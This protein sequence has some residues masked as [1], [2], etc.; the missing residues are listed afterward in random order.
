MKK[1]KH[2]KIFVYM[3]LLSLFGLLMIYSA[4]C[5][6]SNVKYGDSFLFV[7]KQAVGFL[8]GLVLFVFF[9]RFD[10]HKFYKFRWV[11][12]ITSVVLL[13]LVFV[14]HIGVTSNGARRWVGFGAFTIQ[15][16]EVAKFGFVIFAAC[17]MS[18]NFNKMKTF[19]G[20]LPVLISGGCI[21][22]LI[23]LEPNLSVTLCVGMVMIA[24]LFVGGIKLKHFV[25]IAIP[26]L[27]LVPLLIIIEPYRLQRLTAFL[28]PWANPKEEGFQLIQSLYSLG[29]GG[30]WGV[31]LFNS[32][33]KFL[34]LPFSESD[35]IFSII[36][37]EL[38][39]VGCVILCVVYLLLIREG[40]SVAA[41]ADDR[42]GAYLSFGITAV[43]SAQLLINIAV[44]TGSIP[45]TGI[46]L[47][48]ISAGGTSLIMF[49]AAM[50]ILFNVANN[51]KL[52][53][54]LT[55][56]KLHKKSSNKKIMQGW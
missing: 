55:P 20:L 31:G 14:P 16:S 13:A 40:I 8:V 17:Y 53:Y 7:K 24:M 19:K 49:M 48:F 34:F 41:H 35:F 32:R 25:L 33:Q 45:P 29:S 47:P 10:Y 36:G 27:M 51:E 18:K 52:S 39:F 3:I 6:A 44:V 54:K 28:N 11:I 38:G 30:F 26:A 4:S 1:L 56:L 42:L 9:S 12:I 22:M 50:G 23:L 2:K 5:Y 21:C 43:L 46:P 15:S 37:E